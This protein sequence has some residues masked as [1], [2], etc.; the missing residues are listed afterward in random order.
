MSLPPQSP[1][2]RNGAYRTTSGKG[3]RIGRLQITA[4]TEGSYTDF[5]HFC[6]NSPQFAGTISQRLSM[7]RQKRPT[8]RWR[9]M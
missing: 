6:A 3:E 5:R 7:S 8:P 4:K 1:D 9:S 2:L